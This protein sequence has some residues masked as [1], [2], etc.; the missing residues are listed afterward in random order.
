MSVIF[1]FFEK[2]IFGVDWKLAKKK[3]WHVWNKKLLLKIYRVENDKKEED[4]LQKK[5]FVRIKDDRDSVTWP[6]NW[7]NKK[8][9]LG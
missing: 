2:D 6:E 9:E 8:I 7:K 1:V 5:M 4:F 3:N